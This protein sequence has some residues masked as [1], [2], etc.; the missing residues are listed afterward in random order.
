MG[1]GLSATW[2]T[3]SELRTLSCAKKKKTFP[4]TT[5]W[6]KAVMN[7]QHVE[8]RERNEILAEKPV[9]VLG[10]GVTMPASQGWSGGTKVR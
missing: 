6:I 8:G 3:S 4:T 7:L 10:M 2:P 5:T 1:K 9:M